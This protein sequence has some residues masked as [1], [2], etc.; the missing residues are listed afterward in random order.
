MNGI[1]R[2]AVRNLLPLLAVCFLCVA[3]IKNVSNSLDIAKGDG[4]IFAAVEEE[5][6]APAP[7][8]EDPHFDPQYS[9]DVSRNLEVYYK[10]Y[11]ERSSVPWDGIENAQW[12]KATNLE[13]LPYD[14]C[15]W[16]SF[17]FRFPVRGG[18]TNALHFIM[19]GELTYLNAKAL[20]YFHD[21]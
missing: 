3:W 9:A 15:R 7:A 5:M 12:C 14:G 18:L 21:F 8:Q 16:N 13:P 2:K 19:K 4:F 20:L 1:N 11:K 6:S 10:G 17:M